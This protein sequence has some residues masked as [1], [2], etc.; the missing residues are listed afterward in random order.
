MDRV[1][2]SY[3]IH[4]IHRQKDVVLSPFIKRDLPEKDYLV[5]DPDAIGMESFVRLLARRAIG[6]VGLVAE[7]A[8][9]QG[10]SFPVSNDVFKQTVNDTFTY[11]LGIHQKI[12]NR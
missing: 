5:Y 11:Y 9:R 12:P 10:D 8:R 4:P 6:V 3:Y 2:G 7:I 1:K